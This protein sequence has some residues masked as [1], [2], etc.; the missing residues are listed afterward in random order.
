VHL[1]EVDV[2][3]LHGAHN[4]GGEQRGT[5]GAVKAVEGASEAIIAEEAGLLRL[6]AEMFG[7]AAGHPLGQRVEGPTGEQEVSDEGT[8]RDG[9]RDVFRAA[10]DGR[11]VACEERF[12]LE[13]VE[14]ASDDGGGADIEGFEG[15]L[16]KEGSHQCLSAWESGR[17]GCYGGQRESGK[18]TRESKKIL[19]RLR[20]ARVSLARIFLLVKACGRPRKGG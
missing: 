15:G 18:E 6:E 4:E 11:Q 1:V 19:A 3:L 16:V 14:E 20:A 17:E 13:A 10:G 9:R 8:E 5:V 2:K 12:E 7:D